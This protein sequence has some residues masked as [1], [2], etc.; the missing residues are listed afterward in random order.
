MDVSGHELTQFPL[1]LT[2]LAALECLRADRNELLEL[3]AAITA[4][5]RL[6]ELTL[7]RLAPHE[8]PLQLRETR[9]LDVRALGDLSSF[10][11]L[12][13]LAF[14]SCEVTVC[15]SISTAFHHA[16]L[17][18]MSFRLAHPAPGCALTVLLLSNGLRGM[19]RGSVLTFV[20]KDKWPVEGKL[21]EAQGRAPFQKFVTALEACGM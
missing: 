5:S 14:A 16:S 10:P 19:G 2:Q 20:N 3:P 7:G 1:A 11:A 12:R 6:T 15:C 8:D 21:R 9:C 18:S 4:L 13:V 17:A